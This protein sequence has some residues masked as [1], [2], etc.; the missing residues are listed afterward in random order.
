[1]SSTVRRVQAATVATARRTALAAGRQLLPK[2]LNYYKFNENDKRSLIQAY[3]KYR[4]AMTNTNA[5]N[6]RR[7][8][9]VAGTKFANTMFKM[10][11]KSSSRPRPVTNGL[12][13]GVQRSAIYWLPG[14]YVRRALGVRRQTSVRRPASF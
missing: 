9:Q 10:L 14:I 7:N 12:A 2:I 11:N 5:K 3:N 8:A 4:N 1:M 6:A 13:N